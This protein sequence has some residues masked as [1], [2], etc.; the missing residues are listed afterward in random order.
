[1]ETRLLQPQVQRLEKTG[2]ERE[3]EREREEGGSKVN[4][5]TNDDITT[6]DFL[7][8]KRFEDLYGKEKCTINLHLHL[9]LK[10]TF[11]TLV[12]HIR[13]EC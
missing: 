1:M 2:R 8:L 6:A 5:F 10:D 4:S 7:L 9:H 12:L 13:F 11:V 3:R